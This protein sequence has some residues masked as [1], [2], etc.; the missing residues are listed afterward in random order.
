M[1]DLAA[2]IHE[3]AFYQLAGAAIASKARLIKD[4][5]NRAA[6]DAK[7]MQPG[8]A[9]RP[10][11]PPFPM[12]TITTKPPRGVVGSTC[13][14]MKPAAPLDQKRARE[15][16]L[17]G[18]PNTQGLG[19]VDDVLWGDDGKPLAR[20]E[21]KRATRDAREGQQQA[22][23]YADCLEQMFG[24]WPLIFCSNGCQ[25]RLWDDTRHPPRAV[26]GLYK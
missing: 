4:L 11:T 7:A 3:P 26:Q 23:L 24:Q 9:L 14:C 25:R 6:H 17:S 12:P 21:V 19:Y 15:F 16:D 10:P 22:K 13:C 1:R 2:M 20:V 18:L 5:G 8:E